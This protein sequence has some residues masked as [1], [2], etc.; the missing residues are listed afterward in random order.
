MRKQDKKDKLY[1]RINKLFIKNFKSIKKLEIDVKPGINLLVGP[2]GS[3]KSNILEAINFLYKS[4]VEEAGRIP[5]LPHT[6]K[7]WSPEDLIYGKDPRQEIELGISL[8]AT[9]FKYALDIDYTITYRNIEKTITPVKHMISYNNSTIITLTP[10][11]IEIKIRKDLFKELRNIINLTKDKLPKKVFKKRLEILDEYSSSNGFMNLK[12]KPKIK[13]QRPLIEFNIPSITTRHEYFVL[14]RAITEELAYLVRLHGIKRKDIEEKWS[15]I[16]YS[17]RSLIHVAS[18][19]FTNEFIREVLGNIVFLRHPDIGSLREPKPIIGVS[20]LDERATNLAPFLL[21]LLGRYGGWPERIRSAM[22]ELFPDLRFSIK[23]EF[24]RAAL[25][26]VED[27]LE[28]SPANLPDGAIKLLAI[29]AAVESN[30]SILLIDEIE[31]SMHARMLEYIVDQLND[32]DFPVFVATHSP[33]VVD[34]LDPDRIMIVYRDLEKGT[35]I[36]KISDPE[37]LSNKLRELGITLSDYIFYRKT[38]GD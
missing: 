17:K 4:L 19:P 20:R 35:F 8:T 3:G 15:A 2:N 1:I 31:N 30:P 33:V 36:E 21:N 37:K 28:F 10:D 11:Y 32:L 6:P 38:Y 23:T 16:N 9:D 13:I 26:A 12:V 22:N 25:I 7:Y 14:V 5:Y 34:L 24:N 18:F 27:G 29:L